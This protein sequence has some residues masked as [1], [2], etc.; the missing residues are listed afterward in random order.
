MQMEDKKMQEASGSFGGG[1]V[2]KTTKVFRKWI[3]KKKKDA[4]N[5]LLWGP[6]LNELAV[7]AA[8]QR[9]VIYFTGSG[10]QKEAKSC[11]TLLCS[12]YGNT[13]QACLGGRPRSESLKPYKQI[14]DVLMLYR[15]EVGLKH[16]RI[17]IYPL[18]RGRR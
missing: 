9:K 1:Q 7:F 3:K 8:D 18:T 10:C 14:R 5:S 13:K 16:T 11:F 6:D 15:P 17:K 12:D 2:R 4:H